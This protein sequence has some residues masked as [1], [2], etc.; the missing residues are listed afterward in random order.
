MEV[1]PCT[2]TS[3][4]YKTDNLTALHSR[5]LQQ[6][7]W[8]LQVIIN[9]EQIISV[10]DDQSIPTRSTRAFMHNHTISRSAQLSS[11]RCGN[12]HPMMKLLLPSNRMLAPPIR[13][14]SI[15]VVSLRPG[16]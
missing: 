13:A 3:I 14:S 2:S 4:S 1:C 7:R 11:Y 9:S 6:V 5:T 16:L 10:L 12:I 8:F 15:D